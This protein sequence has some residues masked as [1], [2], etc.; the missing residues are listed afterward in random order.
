MD[1]YNSWLSSDNLRIKFTVTMKPELSEYI[2]DMSNEL[3]LTKSRFVEYLV[4]NQ[5]LTKNKL[6]NPIRKILKGENQNC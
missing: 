1:L 2:A 6:P 3:G 5:Y 4:L